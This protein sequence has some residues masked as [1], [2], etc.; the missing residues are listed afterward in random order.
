MQP[1]GQQ[2][3]LPVQALVQAQVCGQSESLKQVQP[4]AQQPSLSRHETM[5]VLRHTTLHVWALPVMT[6]LVHACPSL[7]LCRQ[8]AGGSQVSRPSSTPLPQVTGQSPSVLALQAG[9]QQPSLL[10]QVTIAV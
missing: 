10:T 1:G 7:Q 9:G 8:V 2:P 4:G 5:G 3:S 6:S